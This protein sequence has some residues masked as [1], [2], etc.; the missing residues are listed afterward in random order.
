MTQDEIEVSTRTLQ[1]RCIESRIE[2]KRLLYGRFAISPFRK[3]QAN[4]VGIAM[5]RS[6]LNEIEGTSITYAK[7]NGIKHEYSALVGIQESIHDILINLKEIVLRNDSYESQKVY[8]SV[9]GPRRIIAQDIQR[10]PSIR[11]IDDTQYVATLTGAISLNIE[12][13]IE[14][15]RGYRIGNN[16]QKYEEG[17]FPV[18]AV[19]MPVR[20]ANYS[21]HSFESQGKTKEV[22]F[23]EIWTDGSLTPKEA[24]YEAS[25]NLIDLFIPLMDSER[26][27][28][29]FGIGTN[30]S[31]MPYFPLQFVL[32][33]PEEVTKNVAFKHI[34]IDQLELPARAYNCLKKVNVHTIA[35][36]LDYGQGDLTGI[37][38]FG[39]KSIEQVLEAL[40]KRFS[41]DLPKNK[42]LAN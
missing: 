25:R 22:L 7:I 30:E 33:G 29:S 18:D 14:R 9:V 42:N 36:S 38:N 13:S 2:S 40:K 8:I 4:T 28:H 20:N 26:E 24:L 23:L 21:V 11:V 31:N 34:F 37:K 3:D 1:W 32:P 12:L 6:L 16:L 17:F 15:G 10:P 5:R 19:F 41:I 27:E 39:R 35:D